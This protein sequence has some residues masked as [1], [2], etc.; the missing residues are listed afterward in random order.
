MFDHYQNEKHASQIIW[1]I[2]V[3]ILLLYFDFFCLISKIIHKEVQY[4]QIL[5]YFNNFAILITRIVH[6]I[7]EDICF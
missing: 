5:V 1:S 4:F 2:L 6:L 3:S 7:N